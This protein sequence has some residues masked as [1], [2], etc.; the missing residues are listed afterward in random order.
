MRIFRIAAVGA[1][2]AVTVGCAGGGRLE[3]YPH[4]SQDADVVVRGHRFFVWFHRRENTLMIQRGFGASLG[5]ALGSTL[6]FNAVNVSEPTPYWRAAATA[7][8]DQIGCSMDEMHMLDN[9]I[10]WEAS[11]TCPIG[12][13]V[14]AAV[15]SHRARWRG[16]IVVQQAVM[17]SPILTPAA[18][19]P[20]PR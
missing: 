1:A 3:S 7:V 19:A 6:T 2:L 11:F 9:R 18:R 16:G 15:K 10:T 4:G 8:V 14:D 12:T 20:R 17:P 13:D 5:Q